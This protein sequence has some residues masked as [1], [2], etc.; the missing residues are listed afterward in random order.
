MKTMTRTQEFTWSFKRPRSVFPLHFPLCTFH[1]KRARSSK[2]TVRLISGV[3]LDECLDPERYRTRAPSLQ[4]QSAS[5]N[6][7]RSRALAVYASDEGSS[8][9][10][11]AHQ[12]SRRVVHGE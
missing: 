12:F 3:A 6:N 8:E 1:L 2:R 7:S 10:D 4:S 9:A 11:Q 5:G